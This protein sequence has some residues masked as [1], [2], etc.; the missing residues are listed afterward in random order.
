MGYCKVCPLCGLVT[1]CQP[2][3]QHFTITF[4][5]NFKR[6][7][8]DIHEE[9]SKVQKLL[10]KKVFKK[11][12]TCSHPQL[13]RALGSIMAILA[14]SLLG[15]TKTNKR[16][17]YDSKKN[18]DENNNTNLKSKRLASTDGSPGFPSCLWQSSSSWFWTWHRSHFGTNR[19]K[20]EEGRL[21]PPGGAAAIDEEVDRG[22]DPQEKVVRTCQAEKIG[23]RRKKPEKERKLGE[24]PIENLPHLIRFSTMKS[25]P[26][27]RM[28]LGKLKMVPSSP[29]S[30]SRPPRHVTDG[31]HP[32]DA[33]QHEGK[34]R[35][36]A[37]FLPWPDVGVPVNQDQEVFKLN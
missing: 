2:Q 12:Q 27:M 36:V 23:W 18:N 9:G 28:T 20:K 10:T 8:I 34:V 6:N 37:A 15:K 16:K 26:M 30:S 11:K 33:G 19:S 1:R 4:Q 25:S 21:S 24:N 32:H 5:G 13:S 3:S 31:E 7:A 35:L 14:L 29:S 22:V 17:R